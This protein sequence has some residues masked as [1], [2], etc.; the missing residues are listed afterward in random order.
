MILERLTERPA[1]RWAL[2]ASRSHWLGLLEVLAA[3]VDALAE[4]AHLAR[5]AALPGQI[6]DVDLGGFDSVDALPM[7]GRDL[8]MRQGAA[9]TPWDFAARLRTAPDDW[10][11]AGSPFAL[12]QQVAGLLSWDGA[13]T[14]T[15]GTVRPLLR[16]F[17]ETGQWW[18]LEQGG[19]L[20]YQNSTGT[21]FRYDPASGELTP[22]TLHAVVCDWDSLTE[23]PTGDQGQAGRTFLVVYAPAAAPYCVSTRGT[24]L[25]GV[26][27]ESGW[28]DPHATTYAGLPTAA[29]AGTNAP[30]SL[31]E[32]IRGTIDEVQACGTFVAYVIFAF[33]TDS[34]KPDGSSTHYPDGTWGHHSA[35]NFLGVRVPSRDPLADYCPARPGGRAP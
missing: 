8:G 19:A 14:T 18:T 9:E 24:T 1:V 27:S 31:L 29:T 22:D 23:P 20:L 4:A 21:G 17:D 6:D 25:D 16:L 32:D 15:G 30:I 13:P 28:N 3:T 7:L 35:I 10:C 11:R 5:L 26:W 33:S 34:F 2:R 12:L